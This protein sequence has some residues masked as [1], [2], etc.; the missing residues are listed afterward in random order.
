MTYSNQKHNARQPTG[1]SKEKT[2]SYH[3]T[4]AGQGYAVTQE[5]EITGKT[6]LL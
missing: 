4:E 2:S 5:D 6:K 3:Q 1:S